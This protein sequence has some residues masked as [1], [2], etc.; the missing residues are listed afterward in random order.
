MLWATAW[1]PFE[2]GK[3]RWRILK[4]TV[5]VDAPGKINLSLDITGVRED[6]YHEIDTI[7]Q[8]VDL[9]DTV[10]ITR[11]SGKGIFISCDRPRVPS[12]DTNYAHIAA[13]L[14]FDRFGLDA[15][16]ISIDIQKRLPM[17]AG[18]GGGSADA[19]GVLVGMNALFEVGA[20]MET[21]CRLGRRLVRMCRSALWAGFSGPAGLGNS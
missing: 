10:T 13:R 6:G 19:A 18:M 5:I 21:L 11:M 7:M 4:K 1:E 14:F 9:R 17:Q 12:D 15:S 2:H 8:A 16:A 20:D 3:G